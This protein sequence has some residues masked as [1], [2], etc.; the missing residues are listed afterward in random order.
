[1]LTPDVPLL[2]DL[3]VQGRGQRVDDGDTDA[4]QTTGDRVG[5][6][7]ELSARV[8]R[9]EDDLHGRTLL[10][11]VDTD[12]DT[13]PVVGHPEAAVGQ[14]GHLDGVGVTRQGLVD[15]VVDHL[16]HQV[17]QTALAGGADVHTRALAYCLKPLENRD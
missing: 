14:Q 9:G 13:A 11:G 2:T 17:V 16:V 1:M 10:H 5:L 3:H 15:R 6:S 4:V 8:Q 12:R 7:V